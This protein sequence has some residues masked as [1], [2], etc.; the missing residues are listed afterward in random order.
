MR[1]GRIL[2]FPACRLLSSTDE[3]TINSVPL[4]QVHQ[5]LFI[6]RFV[7]YLYREDL[8]GVAD[9]LQPVGNHNDVFSWVSSFLFSES[10]FAAAAVPA[11][12]YTLSIRNGK[13]NILQTA[14]RT[15]Q[16]GKG[17][18]PKFNRCAVT[19]HIN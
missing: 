15:A 13:V 4:H 1:K 8:I 10:T 17:Y 2:Q 7:L 18:I 6:G 9:G 11:Q 19:F 12:Q 5:V 14:F 16:I 3:A